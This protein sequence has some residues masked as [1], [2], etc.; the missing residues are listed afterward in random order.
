MASLDRIWIKRAHRGLMDPVETA[1]LDAG[2]GIRGNANYGGRRHVTIVAAER[3]AALTAALGADVDPSARRA[4][5]LVSGLELENTRGRILRVGAC[6]LRVGGETRPCERME[7]ACPGLQEA[8]RPHWGGGAWAEVL[9][10]G[11]IRLG[12]PVEWVLDAQEAPGAARE[13]S[14]LDIAAPGS[15]R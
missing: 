13:Q 11:E 14:L 5:L 15:K 9:E 3:W 6:R 12:D 2:R 8:M 4:N 7:E 10:D 1:V